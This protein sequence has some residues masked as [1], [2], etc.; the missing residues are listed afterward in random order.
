MSCCFVE[1]L[2]VFAGLICGFC[3]FFAVGFVG[4]VFGFL[5]KRMLYWRSDRKRFLCQ[6]R[7]LWSVIMGFCARFVCGFGAIAR[8]LLE[9]WLGFYSLYNRSRTVLWGIFKNEAICRFILQKICWLIE[10]SKWKSISKKI[11]LVCLISRMFFSFI[12]VLNLW[13]TNPH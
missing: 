13:N 8:D 5:E 4:C 1:Y 3:L 7:W 12:F 6:K 2:N 9:V 10:K 11:G